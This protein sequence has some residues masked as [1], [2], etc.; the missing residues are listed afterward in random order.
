MI[1]ILILP[2]TLHASVWYNCRVAITVAIL[3]SGKN[4][5]EI[6]RRTQY[7]DCYDELIGQVI[8]ITTDQRNYLTIIKNKTS[9]DY[10]DLIIS[11]KIR[12]G[13]IVETKT[14]CRQKK[15]F[16]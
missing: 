14:D 7:D 1:L 9:G 3:V 11:S 5:V 2:F 6:R 16:P 8:T 4:F 10:V 15:R 13:V 12:C